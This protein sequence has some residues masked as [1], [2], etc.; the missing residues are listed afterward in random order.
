MLAR[1]TFPGDYVDACRARFDRQLALYRDDADAMKPELAAAYAANLV[2]SLEACF[3]H[4][5][6]GREAKKDSA[7]KRLRVLTEAIVTAPEADPVTLTPDEVEAFAG[8]VFA[9]I[10]ER[11][12]EEQTVGV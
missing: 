4:R 10:A 8:E 1:N 5:T 9:E 12:S 2:V 11:F 3:V 7:L 6:R